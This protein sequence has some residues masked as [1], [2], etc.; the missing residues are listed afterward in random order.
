MGARGETV[1][2]L[3]VGEPDYQ[4]PSE[5]VEATAAAAR[6]GNTK[7]TAV[8]GEAKL[9]E[10]ICDDLAARKGVTY[11]PEQ[12][13]VA[14]GAKQSV[15]QSLLTVVCPGDDV[16][17]VAPYWP[18]Y[19]DMVKMCGANPVT[20]NTTPEDG[21]SLRPEAL[22]ETLSAHPKVSCMILCNPSNP[23]GCVMDEDELDGE[24]LR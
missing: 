6:E 23:T 4:P 7:Y 1:Y 3:C 8:G 19:P 18:S 24:L 14:N 13:V 16:L 17:L 2:S 21:Y 10:A 5:V 12:I 15:I 20:V 22:R 9:R 11:K